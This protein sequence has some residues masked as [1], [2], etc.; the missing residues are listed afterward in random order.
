M[1]KVNIRHRSNIVKNESVIKEILSVSEAAE[2]AIGHLGSYG[3]ATLI[4]S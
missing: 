3:D 2:T 4:Q 1:V